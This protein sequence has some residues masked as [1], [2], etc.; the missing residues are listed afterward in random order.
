MVCLAS[1]WQAAQDLPL[2]PAASLQSFS[3]LATHSMPG[4][5]KS[6]AW[7]LRTS[8]LANSLPDLRGD[9]FCASAAN[10][11]GA[12]TI[13]RKTIADARRQPVLGTEEV[14]TKREQRA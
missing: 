11:A 13:T 8:S 2:G 14:T 3:P 12:K 7:S 1:P 5:P 10:A 9:G 4:L 6:S